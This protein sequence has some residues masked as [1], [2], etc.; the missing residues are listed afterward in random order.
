MK[1]TYIEC[2]RILAIIFVIYNHTREL[3]YTLYQYTSNTFSYYLSIFMIPL[4]K[5]AVPVFLMISGATLIGKTENYRELFFKRIMKYSGI[6]LFWG[7][8]Q[9]LRY[10]RTGKIALTVE[11]WWNNIYSVPKLETYW[12]L[13]LYLGFLLLLPLLRKIALGM[14][15]KDYCYLFMLNCVSA[16]LTMIGYF[17]NFFINS[18]VFMLPSVLIYPLL[19]FV[20]THKNCPFQDKKMTKYGLLLLG[21]LCFI[22]T[23]SLVY[24]KNTNSDA[25]FMNLIQCFTPMISVGIFGLIKEIDIRYFH[26]V[27]L[28]KVIIAVGNTVFGIYLMEDMLRNQVIKL[29]VHINTYDFLI[30]ILYTI[31]TFIF[32]VIVV[33]IM[34]RI[35][36]LR[37][38]V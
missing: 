17:T 38:I 33:L 13:Y 10:V 31:L 4:C 36:I 7:T 35:P 26:S 16:V 29:I 23:I 3:G 19:G 5:T 22:M 8:L 6:I 20:I 30:A 25:D 21:S 34:K 12:F 15:A 32:G 11:A 27:K 24:L 18:N 2:L 28:K 9:Y 14:E 1:K 37:K